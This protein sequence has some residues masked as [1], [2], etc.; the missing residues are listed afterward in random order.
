MADVANDV[1]TLSGNFKDQFHSKLEDLMPD[2]VLLQKDGFIDWVP[3]DKMNGELYSIPTLLRS[4]QGVTYLGEGGTVQSLNDA[5]AGLMKEAQVKG[6]EINVRGQLSY[7]ALSQASAAGPKAFV[8]AAGWM[9]EDLANVAYTRLEISALY[10]QSGI[11]TVESVTDNTTSADLVITAA[12]FAP[13]IWVGAEGAYIDSF[14]TTTKNNSGTLQVSRVTVSSRTVR[15]LYSGTIASDCAADDELYFKG[16]YSGTTTWSEMVGLYKQMTDVTNT[17]FNI[18]RSAYTLIQSNQKTSVGA[19]TKAKIIDAAMM[20]VDKGGMS[21]LKCLIS[22]KGWS[23]L[24]AEDLALRSYDSS[25]S[26]EKA[27]S[28]SKALEFSYVGGQIE[29]IAHPCVKAGHFFLF[30]PDD[31]LWCGSSKVSFELPG[32][33]EQF[34]DFVPAKNAVEMQCFADAALYLI[35]PS[36]ACM[37]TGCTF[38]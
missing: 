8:K 1:A 13:G 27:K 32:R 15:V 17:L 5:V 25:Y 4:N 37:G 3:S 7:K 28:G 6:T 22:T 19:V 23:S 26:A 34:F 2:F 9:V 35:R 20:V 12:T 38:S 10:G 16:A 31:L 29:V 36:H 33:S 24:A 18:D 30:N 11:G 21:N 14:T